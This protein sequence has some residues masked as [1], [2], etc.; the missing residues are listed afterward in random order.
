[1]ERKNHSSVPVAVPLLLEGLSL[2]SDDGAGDGR[3]EQNS[4]I[5][6]EPGTI[7]VLMGPNGAGK[8]TLLEKLAGLRNPEELHI[9]YGAEPLWHHRKFRKPRLNLEALRSYSYSSQSPEDGLF[10]R[11]VSDEL[12][13]SLRAYGW[14]GEER[15]ARISTTLEA[16]GWD[17]SW[18]SRDPFLM[19]GG[20][21]RRTALA[22]AFV[23]PSAWLLLDEPTAGLD[24]AG[25]ERVA[26][27]LK[28]L[29][30]EGTGIVLVSHD[31]DWA[32]PLAD[33]VLLLSAEGKMRL[34]S[35]EEIIEHPEWL[36]EAGM[37]VPQWL[38]MAHLLRKN[39]IPAERLWNPKQAA[40]EIQ[41]IDGFIDGTEGLLRNEAEGDHE[42]ARQQF[43]K[44]KKQ[45]K[46]RN[47][48]SSKH[49][50]SGFDPRSVWLAYL[51]LSAG[52]FAQ[53]S[54]IG[55]GVGAIVTLLLLT[56]G[57]ISLR[58]WH[59]VIFSFAFFMIT[60]SA[61]SAIGSRGGSG[62]LDMEAFAGTLFSF[63]RTMLVLLL[64]LAIPLVMSP[65]SL[66][67]SLE[68]LLSIKGKTP[69]FAR[70]I[71]LTV[72]LMMRFVPVLL[73]EWERYTR[74]FLARGKELSR[75]P[76][77]LI[78]RLRDISLPFLLSLFRLGDEVALALESRG[79]RRH[80]QPSRGSKLHWQ[81]RD[82]A[83][84]LGALLFAVGFMWFSRQYK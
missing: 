34:S 73:S 64:G 2:H 71:I 16:V 21:R 32:L 6:L 60:A 40:L 83:L 4:S 66:R 8:T 29:K 19:S 61:L 9:A 51:A 49:R 25:H 63:S 54:W 79:V 77:A 45:S 30:K 14:I 44:S 3:K 1:M 15:D 17:G 47:K 39:G 58:R 23:T 80:V 31:S 18:L 74:I 24:G 22:S 35:C 78:G 41:K 48:N 57:N 7:T 46:K 84:V 65:L 38:R 33:S 42:Q 52:M 5:Q 27:R 36:E 75:T 13:Y 43:Q 20:E 69:E 76:R 68:Q 59:G 53:G 11:S 50:M 26:Q 12:V 67:R 10:A 81:W 28:E 82:S 62:F 72:A 55:L 56:A 37:W 70:R